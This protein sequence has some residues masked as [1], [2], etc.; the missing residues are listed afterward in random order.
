MSASEIRM[1]TRRP[2]L[3]I[4]TVAFTTVVLAAAALSAQYY[5]PTLMYMARGD[6]KEGLEAEPKSAD[7][8]VLL[9][10][11]ADVRP[12]DTY[13]KWPEL[14]RV[15]YFLPKGESRPQMTV[16]QMRSLIGYY[17]L[18]SVDPKKIAPVS[19]AVNEFTWPSS[20]VS[21]VYDFQVAKSG[22]A[23]TRQNW[24]AGLGVLVTL[25][26]TGPIG[27]QTL[28]V[29]PAALHY[30]TQPLEVV[31][32]LLT[33]RTNAPAQVTGVIQDASK[34]NVLSDLRYDVTSGSPFTVRWAV[35]MQP[36]GWYTL[37]LDASLKGQ[38]QIVVRFYH[39]RSLAA[40]K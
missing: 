17:K 11:I 40:A 12:A 38:P 39:R 2:N 6:W 19:G 18:D 4:V 7:A 24:V 9:S 31:S 5:P 1:P 27:R 32:Y 16:R 13:V 35:G 30:S 8:I 25:G 34:H 14:L 36:E 22:S 20:V 15:R 33:F 26:D 10:A 21:R 29:A 23:V 37:L 3:T 28:T